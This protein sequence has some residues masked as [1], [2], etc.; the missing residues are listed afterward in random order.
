LRM[1]RLY[2][3]TILKLTLDSH[4]CRATDHLSVASIRRRNSRRILLE[5]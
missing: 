1:P 3:L 4:F 2:A 5:N